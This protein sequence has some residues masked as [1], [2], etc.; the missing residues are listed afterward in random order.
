MSNDL[1]PKESNNFM[2]QM[3]AEVEGNEN[4]FGEDKVILES[5]PYHV[6]YFAPPKLVRAVFSDEPDKDVINDESVQK[7]LIEYGEGIKFLKSTKMKK[8][9]SIDHID[10]WIN[11]FNQAIEALKY[12]QDIKVTYQKSAS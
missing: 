8:G 7:Y 9:K 10:N 1:L 11:I 2:G 12:Y 5:N 6:C 3:N 4:E